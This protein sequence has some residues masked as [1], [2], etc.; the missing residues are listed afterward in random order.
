MF[1]FNLSSCEKEKIVLLNFFFYY[2]FK[3]LMRICLYIQ[4]YDFILY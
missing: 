2:F 1:N 3:I 4:K